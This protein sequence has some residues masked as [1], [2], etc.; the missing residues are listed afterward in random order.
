MKTGIESLSFY[1]PYYFLDLRTLAREQGIEAD[2]FYVGIGQERMAV[3]PPD[4]DI[5]TMAANA[6]QR[7]VQH[8][9]IGAID[10]VMFATETGIDQSKAAAIYVH[11]LLGLPRNCQSFEIK[12][13]CC[14]STAGLQM[15]L[16]WVARN[17]KKKVLVI[18]SDVARY[19]LNSPGECTQGAGAIAMVV[20]ANPTI[21][22]FDPEIGSYTEDVM[23]FWRPNYRS[24]A[25]VDGKYSIKVYLNALSEAW[26]QYQSVSG[27]SFGDFEHFCYHLPFT[28]MA[29]KAHRHLARLNEQK[30]LP[31]EVLAR[32]ISDG[33]V[34]SRMTGNA[35]TASLYVGLASLL[36]LNR[37]DLAGKRVGLFSYGSGCM[38]T[39]FS[40]TVLP[41]YQE[42]LDTEA[43]RQMLENRQELTYAEYLAHYEHR[44]PTDGSEYTTSR[45][46]TGNFRL[47]GM[48]QHKRLYEAVTS[49]QPAKTSV[50]EA[51]A[52]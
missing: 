30:D 20:S 8:I 36:D 13:A 18:A 2:K 28:R 11:Q 50:H 45:N 29:E 4:E 49:K 9:D 42:H 39:F 33:L 38:A 10:T 17:P 34:Y 31:E 6:A 1:C 5:V 15:A 48:S 32:H 35:Y 44:L 24:E 26:R 7:A 51:A 23:D 3:P 37:A 21:M 46:E 40:G 12:Q 16:A 19:D 52:V 41:G 14:G 27:R 43:H 47:A 25:C 22:T